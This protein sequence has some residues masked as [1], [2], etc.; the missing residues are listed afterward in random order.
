MVS[1]LLLVLL[2][3]FGFGLVII[4]L[5]SIGSVV[6]TFLGEWEEKRRRKQYDDK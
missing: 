2:F 6:M 3:L 4:A 1:E 5:L